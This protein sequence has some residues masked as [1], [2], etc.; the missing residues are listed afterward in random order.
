MWGIHLPSLASVLA[1]ASVAEADLLV[2]TIGVW[3]SST[4]FECTAKV[5]ALVTGAPKGLA[6]LAHMAMNSS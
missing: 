5:A 1:Q 6:V 4:K 3:S 2:C